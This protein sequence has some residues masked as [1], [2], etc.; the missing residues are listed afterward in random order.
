[1]RLID[2]DELKEK[3]EEGKIVI[4]EDILKCNSIHE[5]L[6]YLLEKV[7]KFIEETIDNMPTAYDVEEVVGELGRLSIMSEGFF[8]NYTEEAIDLVRNGGKE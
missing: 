2:A 8:M 3:L 5:Q 6:V 7:D 4:D 1:M